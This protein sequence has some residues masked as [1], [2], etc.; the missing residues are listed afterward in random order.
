MLL[1][2]QLLDDVGQVVEVTA[3]PTRT[4][5]IGQEQAVIDVIS[6]WGGQN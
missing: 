4:P 3:E 2:G 6:S 5:T 1:S